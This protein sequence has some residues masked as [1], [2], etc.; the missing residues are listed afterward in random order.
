MG[1]ICK[2]RIKNRRRLITM[3]LRPNYLRLFHGCLLDPQ[4]VEMVLIWHFCMLLLS[5]CGWLVDVDGVRRYF[6][7]VSREKLELKRNLG[8]CWKI[9]YR[10]KITN[11]AF[12]I[13]NKY[14]PSWHYLLKNLK[15]LVILLN[16]LYRIV[17]MLW[18]LIK[19]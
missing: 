18:I 11:Y 9:Y 10:H 3:R 13:V 8:I 5:F 12:K 16:I 15:I 2:V 19:L 17:T 4:F 7:V 6:L 1:E 14:I